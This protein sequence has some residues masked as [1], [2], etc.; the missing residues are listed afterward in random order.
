M[1]ARRCDNGIYRQNDLTYGDDKMK[2]QEY[3][4][5]ITQISQ[6]ICLDKNVSTAEAIALLN[7]MK[8]CGETAMKILAG[9]KHKAVNRLL[10]KN[11]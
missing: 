1:G 6:A 2:A 3:E 11:T 7:L 4:K 8:Q 5:S 10:R 9:K